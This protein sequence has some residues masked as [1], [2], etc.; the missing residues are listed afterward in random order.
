VIDPF[1]ASAVPVL[2]TVADQIQDAGG[3][4]AAARAVALGIAAEALGTQ[5]W[6]SVPV[7]GAGTYEFFISIYE[8]V[9]GETG[10]F[11][12]EM[13]VSV[14]AGTLRPAGVTRW[15]ESP[16]EDD[17]PS[18]A[19][20]SRAAAQLD[21]DVIAALELEMESL[22]ERLAEPY[23]ERSPASATIALGR[24]DSLLR[25]LVSQTLLTAYARV[26][27]DFFAWLASVTGTEPLAHAATPVPEPVG[28]FLHQAQ[29]P[30]GSDAAVWY[31][32]G[33]ALR[34]AAASLGIVVGPHSPIGA[35]SV[36]DEPASTS[37][38]DVVPG[39]PTEEWVAALRAIC[40]PGWA[41]ERFV[42]DGGGRTERSCYISRAGSSVLWVE[43]QADGDAHLLSFPFGP[44]DIAAGLVSSVWGE[45]H[46]A[47]HIAL[48]TLPAL[49][50]EAALSLADL[51]NDIGE[52]AFDASIPARPR[53]HTQAS[54]PPWAS[55]VAYLEVAA[56]AE[57]PPYPSASVM[58]LVRVF[59]HLE[60]FARIRV[61]TLHEDG[62]S[63]SF[64]LIAARAS[65]RLWVL[66]PN[67]IWTGGG[68][69]PDAEIDVL[70][71]TEDD[72]ADMVDIVLGNASSPRASSRIAEPERPRRGG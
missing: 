13:Q 8:L 37:L 53:R 50:L 45:E 21:G 19:R 14:D 46:I 60:R 62:S 25:F 5:V 9:E 47:D 42:V 28:R 7:P 43:D 63:T 30:L 1:E 24:F 44:N 26:S 23:G 31:V 38:A 41:I 64:G 54:G 17:M 40:D 39:W 27:P 22:S 15:R 4:A 11:E 57:P 71:V 20:L 35:T 70:T 29:G 6:A 66:R 33:A 49:D 16:A 10:L 12:P 51:W 34:D 59:G 48:F 61:L 58:H 69:A 68:L 72:L 18:V 2:S 56:G 52:A 55:V 32:E 67:G 65:E 3:R 36:G